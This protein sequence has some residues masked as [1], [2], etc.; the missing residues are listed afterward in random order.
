MAGQALSP[1][2]VLP[3]HAAV[4]RWVMGRA[5]GQPHGDAGMAPAPLHR[6]HPGAGASGKSFGSKAKPPPGEL[7]SFP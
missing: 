3:G 2:Q 6:R 4:G 1:G 7:K 5:V